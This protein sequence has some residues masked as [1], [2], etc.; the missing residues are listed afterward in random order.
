MKT[1]LTGHRLSSSRSNRKVPRRKTRCLIWVSRRRNIYLLDM[2]RLEAM[3]PEQV[4]MESEW[5]VVRTL[6]KG[7]ISGML[8]SLCH[9][10]P[11]SDALA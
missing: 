6:N 7:M 2:R 11:Q 5:T 9:I 8:T 3:Y 1:A 4:R 10:L